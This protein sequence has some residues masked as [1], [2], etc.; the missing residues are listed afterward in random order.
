MDKKG[1]KI[2]RNCEL[3]C[4]KI[5]AMFPSPAIFYS[6]YLFLDTSFDSEGSNDYAVP[7]DA[8]QVNLYVF[9]SNIFRHPHSVPLVT[10]TDPAPNP[11][12]YVTGPQQ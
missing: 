10:S 5:L 3:H 7:P 4:K 2:A 9:K 12:Q 6:V 11:Y 8:A 1:K